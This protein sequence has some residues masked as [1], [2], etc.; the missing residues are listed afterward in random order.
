MIGFSVRIKKRFKGFEIDTGWNVPPGFTVL[1]GYSGAGKSLTLA[2]IAGFVRPDYGWVRFGSEVLCDTENGVFVPPQ[3]RRFGLVSQTGDLFPHMSVAG[4][5][6]Y[7]LRHLPRTEREDRV[8]AMLDQF[9]LNHLK[10]QH[11]ERLSGGEKQRA[12]LA[13][14]LAPNPRALLLDEPLS[15]VDLPTR[16]EIMDLIRQTR[17][18]AR[19][20]VVMV[21]HDLREGLELADSLVVYSGT[22]VVQ[23]G[24]PHELVDDPATPEIR[25]LLHASMRRGDVGRRTFV[26]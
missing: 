17:E 18:E 5:I 14:A 22:G 26:A 2:S 12:A 19:I 3:K 13:R 24:I 16:I 21:T 8:A 11:P 7:G 4:N 1:F 20:P 15:A 9:G 25:K 10:N 23:S 6:A